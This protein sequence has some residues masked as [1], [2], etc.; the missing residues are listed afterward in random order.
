MENNNS[1]FLV[2]Y[3]DGVR[4]YAIHNNGLYKLQKYDFNVAPKFNSKFNKSMIIRP[5]YLRNGREFHSVG[6][7]YQ[8]LKKYVKH[9]V[10]NS[11][12][13]QPNTMTRFAQNKI[14]EIY[15]ERVG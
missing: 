8:Y 6:L 11:N 10:S 12:V 2:H 7:M 15:K 4:I 13:G 9:T 14:K 5:E 3:K 1:R